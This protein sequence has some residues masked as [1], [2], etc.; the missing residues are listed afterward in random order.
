MDSGSV[1]IINFS[2]YFLMFLLY[3]KKVGVFNAASFLLLVYAFSAFF[4]ILLFFHPLLYRTIHYVEL[5]INAF[6]YLFIVLLLFFIPILKFRSE[7]ISGIVVDK[8][9]ILFLIYLIIPFQLVYLAVFFPLMFSG[10]SGNL[11][12]NRA[13]LDFQSITVTSNTLISIFIRIYG[14]LSNIAILIAF[15]ALVAIRNK[16]FLIKSFAILSF[17]APAVGSLAYTSRMGIMFFI[18]YFIFL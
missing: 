15:Y 11:A 1:I 6:M 2:V 4:S 10:I 9:K 18:L 17:I 5:N 3:Q 16:R 12:E 13:R 14:G 8:K 7:K